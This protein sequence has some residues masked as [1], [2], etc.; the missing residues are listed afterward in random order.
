M[1]GFLARLESSGCVYVPKGLGTFSAKVRPEGDSVVVELVPD[2]G[3]DPIRQRRVYLFSRS[4]R[5]IAAH[6][7]PLA[8]IYFELKGDRYYGRHELKPGWRDLLPAGDAGGA[9]QTDG[10]D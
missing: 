1:T 6:G 10:G 3:R 4:W 7:Q 8:H 9:F 5:R 2:E